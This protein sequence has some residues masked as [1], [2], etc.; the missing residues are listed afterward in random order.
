[1]SFDSVFDVLVNSNTIGNSQ[2]TSLNTLLE[3]GETFNYRNMNIRTKTTSYKPILMHGLCTTG[4]DGDW[5]QVISGGANTDFF[6]FPSMDVSCNISSD[7]SGADQDI[8]VT[9]LDSNYLDVSETV[10]LN[11]QTPVLLTK[12]YFRIQNLLVTSNTQSTD[13]FPDNL[14]DSAYIYDIATSVT[15]GVPDDYFGCLNIGMGLSKQGYYFLEAGKQLHITDALISSDT[16]TT[17]QL[18]VIV[19]FKPVNK[20]F[21]TTM[22]Q[23]HFSSG[24]AHIEF[25]STPPIFDSSNHVDIR[26]AVQRSTGSTSINSCSIKLDFVEFSG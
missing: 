3:E 16:T 25:S 14:D 23:S 18:R 21:W 17:K 11:G 12:K 22:A 20:S 19:Q 7:D 9:G 26:I 2:Q 6:V 13:P 10:T 24:S 8:L 5:R 15:L 4:V 1:M